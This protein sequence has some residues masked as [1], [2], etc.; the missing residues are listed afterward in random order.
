MELRVTRIYQPSL[1]NWY[2]YDPG[3]KLSTKKIKAEIRSK[4]HMK[5]WYL[6]NI[7]YS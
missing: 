5:V 1:L 4:E 6:K 3:S 7:A 2:R